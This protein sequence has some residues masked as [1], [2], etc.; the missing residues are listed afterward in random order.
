MTGGRKW[1]GRRLSARNL[2]GGCPVVRFGFPRGFSL[3]V[4]PFSSSSAVSEHHVCIHSFLGTFPQVTHC[5]GSSSSSTLGLFVLLQYLREEGSEQRGDERKRAFC[6]LPNLQ[7]ENKDILL[8]WL[9]R[10]AVPVGRAVCWAGIL[11]VL[12]PFPT[13]TGPDRASQLLPLVP[14]CAQPGQFI[15]GAKKGVVE[16]GAKLRQV[17]WSWSKQ[18]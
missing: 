8:G 3:H 7:A 5:W 13:G 1:Q 16:T 18:R 9:G 2:C 15:Q 17:W 6:S 12:P 4:S 10:D 14:R 11:L